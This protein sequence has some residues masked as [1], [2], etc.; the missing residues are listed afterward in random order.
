MASETVLYRG[1]IWQLCADMS[2]LLCTISAR[3][4]SLPMRL[5]A[6]IMLW[7]EG[8]WTACSTVLSQLSASA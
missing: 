8:Y 2:L 6:A 3:V 5:C 7:G 1:D 4:V